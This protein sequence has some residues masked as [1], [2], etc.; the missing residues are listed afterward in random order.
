MNISRKN[1]L[2]ICGA[3]IASI[4]S[5]IAITNNS[6]KEKYITNI[7]VNP[8]EFLFLENKQNGHF[9]IALG[10]Y[11]IMQNEETNFIEELLN[12]NIIT[13][14]ACDIH[15]LRKANETTSNAFPNLTITTKDELNYTLSSEDESLINS[16]QKYKSE[17]LAHN[18]DLLSSV[19]TR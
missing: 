10:G 16:V 3:S 11:G 17:I 4:I 15:N 14:D 5:G 1:F 7:Q 12:K 2:L 8:D 6:T 19:K 13:Y 9:Y 18:N